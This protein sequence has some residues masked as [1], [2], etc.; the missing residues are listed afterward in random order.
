M[1]P[2]LSALAGTV[3][4]ESLKLV[5]K[6]AFDRMG[7]FFRGQHGAAKQPSELLVSESRLHDHSLR[8][9]NWASTYTFLGLAIP[10]ESDKET[11]A[12]RF[13]S[14]P[15]KYRHHATKSGQVYVSESDLLGSTRNI[16]VLGEPGAG[17]TTTLR[18]IALATLIHEPEN[19]LDSHG[20]PILLLLRE[21]A[22]TK[23]ICEELCDIFGLKCS[24]S[25][26]DPTLKDRPA[27]SLK[28]A[29]VD[30]KIDD[31]DAEEILA[32]LLDSIRAVLLLDGLDEIAPHR[33]ISVE[34]EI[35]RLTSRMGHC[36][37]IV[38][39]RSGDFSAPLHNFQV[40]EIAPLDVQEIHE[41]AS[42]WLG[43][44]GAF[45]IEL[46]NRPYRDIVDRPLLLTF[47]LF[48]FSTEGSLPEQ[49]SLIYRRVVYR[50]LREWD[51]ERRIKRS[52]AYAHFDPDRKT[53]FLSEL[54]Y[55]LTYQAQGK[56][57]SEQLFAQIYDRLYKRYRLPRTDHKRIAAE[58]QTHTGIIVATGIESFEFAHLSIQEYLC[59]NHIV[60]EPI[61]E[62]LYRYLASY[63]AP[64]AVACALSSNPS[65]F[66]A[67]L[68]L[69]HLSER[70][71]DED[72]PL[73]GGS[74]AMQLTLFGTDS[75]T[76]LRSFLSRVLSENPTFRV[77]ARLGE[78]AIYLFAFY[79]RRYSLDVDE[80]LIK[81][82]RDE[83]VAESAAAAMK[84]MQALEA[85]E[86]T[87]SAIAFSI[88]EWFAE[89]YRRIN[90][91]WDP[92]SEVA[93]RLPLAILP[94][95]LFRQLSA[96]LYVRVEMKRDFRARVHFL[97][98]GS[99]FCELEN[100]GHRFPLGMKGCRI[101][102]WSR[103]RKRSESI[104]R[105]SKR[106]RGQ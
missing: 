80:L 93:V 31:V 63:P 48:L 65:T 36:N 83:C 49:P 59:A 8:V 14:A 94:A 7:T 100:R 13:N 87:P 77:D 23:F 53:D 105:R 45:L 47:L 62:L 61:P 41:L 11:I 84:S 15:R 74:N 82:V 73:H 75:V 43:D 3:E 106:Q 95:T 35:E 46:K 98:S 51:E 72:D 6:A 42:I 76:T 1:D 34:H 9:L 2:T 85:V 71:R 21:I 97:L 4:N 81:F 12:L 68:I 99:P 44:P 78:A 88:D 20:F 56:S 86:V 58:L 102:G 19:S 96:S 91:R 55:E 24:R 101:C 26:T 29:D 104:Y 10:K 28:R 17:K 40:I 92:G 18:R 67:E 25:Y 37:T 66:F 103:G 22:R 54:A 90:G 64:V 70:V 30:I 89:V 38:S 39:C 52:S 5:V 69:R 50:L 79:Y 60:R 16:V 57:F 33:R 32:Q 27:E